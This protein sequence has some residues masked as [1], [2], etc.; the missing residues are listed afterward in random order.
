M[1]VR[2]DGFFHATVDLVLRPKGGANKSIESSHLQP[3]ADQANPTGADLHT[4][5]VE[6]QDQA[7][8]EGE[9]G[10]AV[11]KRHDRGTRIEV[12]L[13]RAPR[14]ESFLGWS[15]MYAKWPTP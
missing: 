2:H 7:V 4:Y 12:F 14:V 6:R 1:A 15:V 11:K 9:T 13:I 10:N 8:Q 5:Q 3:E